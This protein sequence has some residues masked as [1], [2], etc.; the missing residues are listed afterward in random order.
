MD[1]YEMATM[2]PGGYRVA[3]ANA[4]GGRAQHGASRW[5][6]VMVSALLSLGLA[7]MALVAPAIV[8]AHAGYHS[9][10][11]AAGA[12]VKA[13]PT[14]VTVHFEENVNPQGSDIVIYDATHKPVSTAPAQLSRSDLKTMTVPMTGDGD[15]VYLVEWH[16]VSADDGDPDIGG[17]NFTVNSKAT[18]D[19]TPT[20][21][22]SQHGTATGGGSGG[23]PIWLAVLIGV[24]GLA[25][26][27]AGGFYA[28]RRPVA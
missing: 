5:R 23:A 8:S 7:V 17:F 15:G 12:V 9:S 19:T 26:G 1:G 24:I 27:G 14:V 3:S 22:S 21:T 25:L 4:G 10:D 13:A 16:T 6:P 18:A 11:P 20:A 28:A 2:M